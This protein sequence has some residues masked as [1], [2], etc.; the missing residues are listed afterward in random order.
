L[1]LNTQFRRVNNDETPLGPVVDNPTG[2]DVGRMI[3]AGTGWTAFIVTAVT[4]PATAQQ[5]D[6]TVAPQNPISYAEAASTTTFADICA[7][8]GGGIPIV[9]LD[10]TS[11]S[12]VS[13]ADDALSQATFAAPAGFA[14]WG[15]AAGS[16]RVSSNGWLSFDTNQVSSGP[17]NQNIPDAAAPNNVVAPYWDDLI[18]VTACHKSSATQEIVQWDGQTRVGPQAVHF[19]AILDGTSNTVTFVWAGTQAALGG[20]ATIGL[21]D[22]AGANAYKHSYNT[23]SAITAGTAKV[24][25]PM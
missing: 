5:Y 21:E 22:P 13:P 16:F 8:G 25:T 20:H 14:F 19:Q 7:V 12:P 18:T 23:A 1:L 15:L 17:V 6:V 10:D 24:Y 11:G 9:L 2:D 3:Q 4:P